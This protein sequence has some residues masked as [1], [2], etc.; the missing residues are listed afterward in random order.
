MTVPDNHDP[1]IQFRMSD[2]LT[3]ARLETKINMILGL[4]T[5]AA[6]TFGAILGYLIMR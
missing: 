3:I 6:T 1:V 5:I 2:K 4:G